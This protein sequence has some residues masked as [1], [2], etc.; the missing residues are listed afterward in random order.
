MVPDIRL[1]IVPAITA[2]S[3]I[4][5]MSFRRDGAIPPSPPNKMAMELRFANPQRAKDTMAVV[6]GDSTTSAPSARKGA[7][8]K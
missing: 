6:F 5:A 3:P 8:F 2:N 4:R 7:K 1:D